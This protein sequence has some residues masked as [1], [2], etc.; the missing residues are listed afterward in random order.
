MTPGFFV[1]RDLLENFGKAFNQ[2]SRA[3]FSMSVRHEFQPGIADIA[4][5]IATRHD[6]EYLVSVT[7]GSGRD[8]GLPVGDGAKSFLTRVIRKLFHRWK[9]DVCHEAAA[10]M[11]SSDRAYRWR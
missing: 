1:L 4:S 2:R 3:V 7:V 6:Y 9:P 11:S 10:E 8:I 5:G